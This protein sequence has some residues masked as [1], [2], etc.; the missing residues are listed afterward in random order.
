MSTHSERPPF[1]AEHVG[2]LLRPAHLIEARQQFRKKLIDAAQLRQIEDDAIREVV[3]RQEAIGLQSISDGEFRR[4]SYIVDFF[5]KAVGSGGLTAE[6]GEFFHRN[7]R[8]ETIPMEKL[9]LHKPVKWTGPIFA[10][11]F[12]FVKSL[13]TRTPKM[14]VP[15]PI[16]LHF[17]G[18]SDAIL[19][20][21]YT[22]L[23]QFWSDVVEVYRNEFAALHAAGISTVIFSQM[24]FPGA[25]L[26]A[27]SR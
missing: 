21:A 3:A 11:H 12:A 2:S 24:A 13:T 4:Q 7:E 27:F 5:R 20:E 1:R 23:D 26:A 6:K 25:S 9:V 22:S 17:L 15:S 18:G 14:T 19:R 8:G 16:V 10:E